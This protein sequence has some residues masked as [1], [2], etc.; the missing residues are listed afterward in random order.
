M[1]AV[2]LLPFED[3]LIHLHGGPARVVDEAHHAMTVP[4]WGSSK[5][6][7][8]GEAKHM[9]LRSVVA[10]GKVSGFWEFDPEARMVVYRGFEG[11]SAATQ[12][13]LD[14]AARDIWRFLAEDIGHGRSFTLDTDEELRKRSAQIREM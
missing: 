6:T 13:K 1:S 5:T 4:I 9:S 3:N 2:A 7:T 12:K 8:I 11:L 14:A 10:E